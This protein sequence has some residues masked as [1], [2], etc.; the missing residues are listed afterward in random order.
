MNEKVG[1]GGK[2]KRVKEEEMGCYPE[3]VNGKRRRSEGGSVV[4]RGAG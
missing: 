1:L 3:G 2:V 4:R